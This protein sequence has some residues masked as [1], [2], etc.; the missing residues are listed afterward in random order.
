VRARKGRDYIVTD[1]E[2]LTGMQRILQMQEQQEREL[3]KMSDLIEQH[4]GPELR[5]RRKG[6]HED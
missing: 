3:I 6:S 2:I 4:F 5:T 1:E